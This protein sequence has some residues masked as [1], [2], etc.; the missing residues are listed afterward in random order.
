MKRGRGGTQ[1]CRGSS[2]VRRCPWVP[3]FGGGRADGPTTP[4]SG[5]TTDGDMVSAAFATHK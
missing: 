3:G 5:K 4:E 2:L 1:K